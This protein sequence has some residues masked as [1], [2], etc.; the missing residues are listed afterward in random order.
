MNTKRLKIL[1]KRHKKHAVLGAAVFMGWLLFTNAYAMTPGTSTIKHKAFFVSTNQGLYEP[2]DLK[3]RRIHFEQKD[4][5]WCGKNLKREKNSLNFS[6]EFEIP[7]T[8]NVSKLRK[9]LSVQTLSVD[10]SGKIHIVELSV[11]PEARKILVRTSF[12]KT[13]IDFDMVQFNKDFLRVHSKMAQLIFTDA[14]SKYALEMEI[15]ESSGSLVSKH[16]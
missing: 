12:D 6:C 14:L 2:L 1:F 4:F 13:G 16:P 3:F 10:V 5:E 7:T 8:A 15:L 9:V 11:D